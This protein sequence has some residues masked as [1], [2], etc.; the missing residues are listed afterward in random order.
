MDYENK[1]LDYER[2][3]HVYNGKKLNGTYTTRQL[4][5]IKGHVTDVDNCEMSRIRN[6]LMKNGDFD[7][8]NAVDKHFGIDPDPY[9]PRELS[10]INGRATLPDVDEIVCLMDKCRRKGDTDYEDA[11]YVNYYELLSGIPWPEYGY[12]IEEA[13]A[14]L[15]SLSPHP[16]YW[17]TGGKKAKRKGRRWK[18]G[19][20]R[21]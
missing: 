13:M 17:G 4:G 19:E 7:A 14:V 21:P 20:R 3:Y 2:I 10:Y 12:N 6:L 1:D 16:L 8:L 5:V 9:A 18:D 15:D 11:L